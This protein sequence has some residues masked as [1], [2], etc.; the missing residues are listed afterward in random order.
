MRNLNEDDTSA[1][2]GSVCNVCTFLCLA[3]AFPFEQLDL[4]FLC[5]WQHLNLYGGGE[6][7]SGYIYLPVPVRYS[8]SKSQINT[9]QL[10]KTLSSFLNNVM[11]VWL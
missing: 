8:E 10:C 11:Q 4:L 1:I 6:G 7:E 5:N 3:V 2:G 9:L